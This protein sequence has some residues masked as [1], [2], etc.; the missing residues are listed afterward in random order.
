M[1]NPEK[2]ERMG[3]QDTGLRQTKTKNTII[4]KPRFYAEI[5]TDITTPN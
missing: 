5:V 2:L 1:D 4:H 3:T